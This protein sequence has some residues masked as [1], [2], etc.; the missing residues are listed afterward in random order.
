MELILEL[1]LELKL[2][3]VTTSPVGGWTKTTLN[4]KLI[5]CIKF[6][7]IVL[8]SQSDNMPSAHFPSILWQEGKLATH[9]E[10]IDLLGI[11][12]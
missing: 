8:K 10:I 6:S 5:V 1:N 4:A 12:G 7:P 2:K 3:L 11:N 9:F